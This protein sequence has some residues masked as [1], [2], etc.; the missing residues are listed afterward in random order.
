M[1]PKCMGLTVVTL[2]K[3]RAK[4]AFGIMC[5]VIGFCWKAW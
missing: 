4:L 5:L 3:A 1:L 2:E